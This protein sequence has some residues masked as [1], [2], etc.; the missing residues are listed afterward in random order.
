MKE[1]RMD[2]PDHLL[3]RVS[4]AGVAGGLLLFVVLYYPV[5][6]GLPGRVV[7]DWRNGSTLLSAFLVFLGLALLSFTGYWAARRA[8]LRTR[9]GNGLAGMFAGGLAA[10][11][12]YFSLMGAGA[13]VLGNADLFAQGTTAA[14]SDEALV[15]LFAQAVMGVMNWSYGGMTAVTLAG[16]ALGWLGGWLAP[17]GMENS[18]RNWSRQWDNLGG[19]SVAFTLSSLLTLVVTAVVYAPLGVELDGDAADATAAGFEITHSA[20]WAD[21]GPL[22]AAFV[23]YLAGLTA[24]FL[25]LRRSHRGQDAHFRWNSQLSGY[26]NGGVAII[27]P[28]IVLPLVQ[29]GTIAFRVVTL[30][31]VLVTLGLGWALLRMT[32]NAAAREDESDGRQRQWAEWGLFG[33]SGTAVLLA[34]FGLTW[35]GVILLVAAVIFLAATRDRQPMPRPQPA[36]LLAQSFEVFLPGALALVLPTMVLSSPALGVLFLVVSTIPHTMPGG[37]PTPSWF[38]VRQI[39]QLFIAHHS[40]FLISLLLGGLLLGIMVGVLRLTL[41]RAAWKTT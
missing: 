7:S 5:Y 18:E 37:E 41:G 21:I 1:L 15:W 13:A 12:G 31:G 27:L 10:W 6:V 23:V 38:W 36:Q 24:V 28:L 22:L 17:V 34:W 30:L 40:M 20:A 4:L 32:L 14:A 2:K 9:R 16:L 33:A 3:N 39:N 8:Q 25:I 29:R 19:I 26:L 11:I 35:I